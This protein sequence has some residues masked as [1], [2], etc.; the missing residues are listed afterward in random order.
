MGTQ[1]QQVVNSFNTLGD[2]GFVQKGYTT[3]LGRSADPAGLK[4]YVAR[5]RA[6]VSRT[7]VWSELAGS[8]EAKRFAA[9]QPVKLVVP[10]IKAAVACSLADLLALD[11]AEFVRQA[12]QSVLGREADPTGLRDYVQRLEEG[13]SRSQ[14]LADLRCDPEGKAFD[15]KLVGLDDWVKLVQQ[16]A[17]VGD[18]LVLHGRMFL[19]AAYVA[20]FKREPDPDG[21]ARYIALLQSGASR[22]FVLTELFRSPEAREKG[23]EVRGL[24]KAI[25]QYEKAQRK[26]WGG[27]YGRNVLGVESDLPADCERRALAY[28]LADRA[29]A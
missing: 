20:L 24:V 22:T 15:S 2:D 5:L 10:Q 27:W 6:G 28:G 11:G 14:L 7:Q 16:Q 12:Y 17:S 19:T 29:V 4:D 13:T 23:S 1:V 18:L 26:S 21:F 3:L 25:A 8:D 9:R